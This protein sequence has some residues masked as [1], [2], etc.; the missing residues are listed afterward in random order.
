[1]R[2]FLLA[3][4]MI[5][6][7]ILVKSQTC[8]T[9]GNTTISTNPNTYYPGTQATVAAGSTS[10][11]L[12][13]ATIGTTA[14]SS[15]DLVLIIQMQGAEIN[16][17]NGDTYGDGVS[18]GT[19]SGY[20]NNSNHIAGNLEYAVAT[21][22]VSL[23]GGTLNISSG[24]NREYRN[25]DYGSFGQYRFQ[26]IRVPVYFNATLGANIAAPA[27]TGTVG[28]VMAI[29]T[30]NDFSFAGFSMNAAGLGFRGGASQQLGGGAGANTDFSTLASVNNNAAKGEGT[31]GMPRFLNN[32]GSLLD[33]GAAVEGY[34]NGSNG[35][36]SPGNAGGGGT[37]GNPGSNDQ[38]SGGGGGANGGTG[39]KGGNA[40]NSGATSG[41]EPAA[42]FAQRAANR[43][44]MGG[45]GGGGSTNNGTGTPGSGFAS[46]GAA[47]GGIIILSV[48]NITSAGTINVNGS[49]A[50]NTVTNDGS[51]GG[52]GGG[53][54]LVFAGSGHSNVTITANG[55]TGGTNTGGG[56]SHGPGGGGGGGVIYSNGTLNAGSTVTAGSAGTTA[57]GINFGAANGA[58]G[59]ITQNSTV[60][61]FPSNFNT[62][63]FLPA[64]LLSL[65]Y[66]R[67]NQVLQLQWKVSNEINV[68]EYV[69]EKSAN[70]NNFYYLAAINASSNNE[71]VKSYQ[72]ADIISAGTAYY[73]LKIVDRDG[74]FAYSKVLLYKEALHNKIDISIY[75]NPAAQ[76]FTVVLPEALQGKQL[77]VTIINLAG[78]KVAVQQ[79]AAVTN[80][81]QVS[82]PSTVKGLMLVQVAA[83][84]SSQTYRKTILIE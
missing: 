2:H 49:D 77:T 44:V 3:M 31:A 37:D 26:V 28:G 65:S 10:I 60:I 42:T 75:P 27:W 23:A 5:F 83:G 41:G 36:G 70:G 56:A 19:G 7:V 9:S 40:W 84:N 8:P 17:T 18:G 54:V 69:V 79:L 21:N 13:A 16:V 29:H 61:Q 50:N 6:S 4:M 24:T 81:L 1:M 63:L 43:I 67:Q 47:G 45:G 32:A 58:N 74:R 25:S 80:Q 59:V 39:G 46:S 20:L 82:V 53:S 12:G 33:N 68:K 72:A 52:G 34:P 48:R 78:K 35:K 11:T 55:G 30:L 66:T 62:C 51:G 71:N 76:Q 15:G 64:Q 14:I 38:N 73:R 57:G 22:S